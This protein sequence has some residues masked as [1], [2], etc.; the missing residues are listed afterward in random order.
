MGMRFRCCATWGTCCLLSASRPVASGH[1]R[2]RLTRLQ[3]ACLCPRQGRHADSVGSRALCGNEQDIALACVWKLSCFALPFGV[4]PLS[5]LTTNPPS[6]RPSPPMPC[7]PPTSTRTFETGKVNVPHTHRNMRDFA[8]R[9]G[10]A[11]T[12][13]AVQ[14]RPASLRLLAWLVSPKV[15]GRQSPARRRSPA[16]ARQRPAGARGQR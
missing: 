8:M 6:P 12:G 3:P 14:S 15:R 11:A 2:P 1:D 5:G 9:P 4:S 10:R 16:G 7:R 13:P